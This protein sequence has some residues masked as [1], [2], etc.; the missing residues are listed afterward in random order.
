MANLKSA[1]E[2]V[3]IFWFRQA[4]EEILDWLYQ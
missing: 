2:Q 3:L 1:N 4:M